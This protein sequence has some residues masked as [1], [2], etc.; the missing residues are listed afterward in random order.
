MTELQPEPVDQEAVLDAMRTA[1][2]GV[3]MSFG[4]YPTKWV[5]VA[6]ALGADRERSLWTASSEDA[7]SWDVLGMLAFADA[8]YRAQ[9][10]G[11]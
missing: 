11:D 4:V 5:L 9:I 2:E 8:R 10:G 3:L 1:I 7:Q 6:E